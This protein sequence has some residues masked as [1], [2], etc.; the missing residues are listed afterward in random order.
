MT[1]CRE[2]RFQIATDLAPTATT[3]GVVG[4]S[5]TEEMGEPVAGVEETASKPE[6]MR[7]KLI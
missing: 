3:E 5:D 2:D 7:Y 6:V 1:G 4:C